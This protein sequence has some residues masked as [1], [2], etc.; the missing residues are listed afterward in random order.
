MPPDPPAVPRSLS[1]DLEGEFQATAWDILSAI[2]HGFRAQVDVKGKLA[3]YFLIPYLERLQK[4][5]VIRDLAWVDKDKTPDF[6]FVA[7]G[8][9]LLAECKNILSDKPYK[10]GCYKIELEKSR[11]S[12]DGGPSRGYRSDE[13]HIL[14][15]CLFNHTNKWEYLFVATRDL[16]AQDVH[17]EYLKVRQR[18]PTR[19][20][21]VWKQDLVDVLNSLV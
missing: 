13:Y 10:D 4:D 3:E 9:T 2:R 6:S 16:E 19:A 1:H 11:N 7:N 21:G 12:K 17:T 8:M 20:S 14:I 5:G 15:A 18:V